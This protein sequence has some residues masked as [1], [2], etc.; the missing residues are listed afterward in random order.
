MRSGWSDLLLFSLQ[1]TQRISSAVW[2]H[3]HHRRW[4]KTQGLETG[5]ASLRKGTDAGAQAQLHPQPIWERQVT[6]VGGWSG[7][8]PGTLRSCC[9]LC[10]YC[11]FAPLLS[12]ERSG[13]G[14]CRTFL[15]PEI[16][17]LSFAPASLTRKMTGNRKGH[18]IGSK[19]HCRELETFSAL[20]KDTGEKLS[21]VIDYWVVNC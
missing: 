21:L 2:R 12:E 1:N 20:L 5:Q 15:S 10:A 19:N 13:P 4:R 11:L 3:C 8:I 9:T 14:L 18:G 17:S 6:G 16:S 7:A